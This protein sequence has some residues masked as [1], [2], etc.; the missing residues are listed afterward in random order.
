MKK[1]R[2]AKV[3]FLICRVSLGSYAL[4]LKRYMEPTNSGAVIIVDKAERPEALAE[5]IAPS[6]INFFLNPITVSARSLCCD[7]GSPF[8][9][10]SGETARNGTS[11]VN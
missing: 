9:S 8:N 6:F 1:S 10:E 4:R 11:F 5:L 2:S 7:N 3:R